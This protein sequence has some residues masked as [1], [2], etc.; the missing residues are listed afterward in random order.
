MYERELSVRSV[1][2]SWGESWVDHCWYLKRLYQLCLSFISVELNFNETY[3]LHQLLGQGGFAVVYSGTRV[4]DN[5]PVR[6]TLV[7]MR[8]YLFENFISSIWDRCLLLDS[9]EISVEFG[10]KGYIGQLLV[11]DILSLIL[12][13]SDL[14]S[15]HFFKGRVMSLRPSKELPWS[16][17]I[18]IF[19][20]L[21]QKRN[22]YILMIGRETPYISWHSL[23]LEK[24]TIDDTTEKIHP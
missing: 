12:V 17:W 2:A 15:R 21:Q 10:E 14:L 1:F 3:E 16:L 20:L 5:V 11:P 8:E 22:C 4:R 13:I 6:R 7:Y 23:R 24:E 9:P 19:S 18:F